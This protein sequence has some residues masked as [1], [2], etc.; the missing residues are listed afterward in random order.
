[1]ELSMGLLKKNHLLAFPCCATLFA[2]HSL[3]GNNLQRAISVEKWSATVAPKL[4][5]ALA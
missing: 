2:F 3:K 4:P 1:M 5:S